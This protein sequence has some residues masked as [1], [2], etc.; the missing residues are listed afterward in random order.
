[1]D[2]AGLRQIRTGLQRLSNMTRARSSMEPRNINLSFEITFKQFTQYDTKHCGHTVINSASYE[3]DL[4]FEI[5]IHIWTP[6]CGY[7][8]LS[9][10]LKERVVICNTTQVVSFQICSAYNERNHPNL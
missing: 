8:R 10:C 9:R 3:E 2:R 4:G 6:A 7:R 1:M 5:R